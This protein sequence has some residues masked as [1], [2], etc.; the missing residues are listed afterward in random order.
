MKRIFGL[1]RSK[2]RRSFLRDD[3]GSATVEAVLWM[4][5]FVIFFLAIFEI[6]FAFNGH[7]QVMR[8]VQDGNRAFSVGLL[9]DEAATEAA[10]T[11]SLEPLTMNPTVKTVVT[12]GNIIDTYAIVPVGDLVAFGSFAW[13]NN[14]SIKVRSQHFLEL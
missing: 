11:K 1:F 6:S 3:S 9:K 10:I 13:L 5:I 8:I 12:S 4:P 14:Y 7:A 2:S